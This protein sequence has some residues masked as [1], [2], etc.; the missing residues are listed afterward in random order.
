MSNSRE[1]LE[2]MKTGAVQLVESGVSVDESIK[3]V[4]DFL[5]SQNM[6]KK[7]VVNVE[8][9]LKIELDQDFLKKYSAW[10]MKTAK[11]I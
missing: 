5:K 1:F 10:I 4:S 3:I 6:D 9:F 11:N 8:C 7:A 2:M